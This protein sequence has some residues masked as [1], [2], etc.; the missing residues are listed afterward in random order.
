MEGSSIMRQHSNSIIQAGLIWLHRLVAHMNLDQEVLIGVIQESPGVRKVIERWSRVCPVTQVR[1]QAM[2][3]A[4]IEALE[5]ACL[6]ARHHIEIRVDQGSPFSGKKID[7]RVFGHR[8]ALDFSPPGKTMDN[9]R[10]ESDNATVRRQYHGQH[11]I[12]DPIDPTEKI[13]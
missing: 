2:V 13:E 1:R 6:R 11:S 9:A 4:T 8:V 10:A 12:P 5:E 7:L 3:M